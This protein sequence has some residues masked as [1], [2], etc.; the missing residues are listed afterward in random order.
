MRSGILILPL[1]V[2]EGVSGFMSGILMHQFNAHKE[3]CICGSAMLTL[4]AGLYISLG[5]STS[6]TKFVVFELLGG[7]GSGLPFSAPLIA[8]QNETTQE[9]VATAT[10]TQGFVRNTATAIGLVIGGV[11][12]QNSM[13]ERARDLR[14]A[15]VSEELLNT[16]SGAEA[17][18]NIGLIGMI[19]DPAQA[20][21]VK[22]AFAW[23]IRNMWIFYACIAVVGVIAAFFIR[24]SRL[25]SEHVET[26]TGL[27]TP[28]KDVSGLELLGPTLHTL[29]VD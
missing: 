8:I 3:L 27:V 21:A 28:K 29:S 10:A 18:A 5:A 16:F 7:I 20:L 11:I 24:S 13:L 23:S 9:H 12:F 6:L 17:A 1:F 4:G 15:G 22:E 26:R 14:R 25:S 2:T 19:K